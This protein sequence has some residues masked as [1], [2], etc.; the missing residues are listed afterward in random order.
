M[1]GDKKHSP[2]KPYLERAF[3]AVLLVWFIFVA[4]GAATVYLRPVMPWVAGVVVLAVTG[5]VIAALVRWRR[6]KW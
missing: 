3:R 5:W 2:L 4:I 1:S 6:S